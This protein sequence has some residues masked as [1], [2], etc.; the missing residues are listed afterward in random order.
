MK[1]RTS[2]WTTLLCLLVA[3][4]GTAQNVP[5]YVPGAPLPCRA[6]E[7]IQRYFEENGKRY[8]H[9]IDPKTG[10]PAESGLLSVTIISESGTE[11]DV[12][13]TA[14]YVMGLEKA[15]DFWKENDMFEAIFITEEG[16][17]VATE[18]AD[19]CFAFEGRDNDFTYRVVERE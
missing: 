11:A 9:I 10:Y 8:H 14:L 3:L 7:Q 1:N 6:H 15:L 19:A 16:E 5:G 4:G 18:G 17:V 2:Y 12:L 13:S